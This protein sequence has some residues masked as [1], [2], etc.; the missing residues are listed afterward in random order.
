VAILAILTAVIVPVVG[1]MRAMSLRVVCTSRLK[2]LTL[3]CNMYRNEKLAYP[4]QPGTTLTAQVGIYVGPG[5]VGVPAAPSSPTLPPPKPTDMDPAFLN[6]L[7]PYLAIPKL[8]AAV[9]PG[10][11][12]HVLQSPTVEDADDGAR[13]TVTE[14]TF[15][16]PALYTGYAYCVRPKDAT[17]SPA[18]KLLKRDDVASPREDGRRV[19]WADDVHWSMADYAWSFSHAVPHAKPGQRPLTYSERKGLLGQ[20]RAFSDGSVEWV[21]SAEIDLEI[22]GKSGSAD[23]KASLSVSDLFFF[24]F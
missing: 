11:L 4:V 16:K 9:E 12:P 15:S 23:K 24:W 14:F 13:Q 18:V 19:I 22:N 2:D 21:N 17:L 10:D 8:D 5:S 1:R 3:A 7:Q 6:V 20:H